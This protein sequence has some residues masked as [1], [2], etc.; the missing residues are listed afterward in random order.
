MEPAVELVEK[1]ELT[2]IAFD[3]LGEITIADLLRRKG[4]DATKGYADVS[5]LMRAMLPRCAPRGVKILTNSGGVNPQAALERAVRMARDG[6]L[7]KGAQFAAVVGED[8]AG[9]AALGRIAQLRA[10]GIGLE[11]IDTGQPLEAIAD[12]IIGISFYLGASP[13]VEALEGGA[14]VVVTGRHTDHALWLAPMMHEFGWRQDDWDLLAAGTVVAH[15]LECTGQVTGG[16][17]SDWRTVEGLDRL[18]YPLAEVYENGEALITKVPGSGGMV[19]LATCKEQ[20]LYEV[21]DPA[22]YLTP[23]VIADFT[24]VRL[25]QV[26][27]DRVKVWDTRGRRPPDTLKALIAYRDGY[28]AEGYATFAWPEALAKAQRAE[29]VL[30][31]RLAVAK[32][33]LDELRTD[34]VGVNA[35]L[36]PL[37]PPLAA[38]PN[39]V[40][41]RVAA[42][43][44]SEAEVARLQQEFYPLYLGG[45]AGATGFVLPLPRPIV[46]VWPTLVPREE[47]RA[48]VFLV[49]V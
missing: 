8:A 11:N 21:G 4:E 38:E 40:M 30:R 27:Q 12:R 1:G 29:E 9:E 35:L 46:G 48:Q 15:L 14:Q 24:T 23:D 22:N 34:I 5:R 37:A 31:G 43:G 42:K 33:N 47:I 45:P 16:G 49:E 17:F 25:A 10:K 28:L 32:V 20:L 18:G 26:G 6:G 13:I 41:L 39:E 3:S 19:T 2:H 7:W 36:G 44:R